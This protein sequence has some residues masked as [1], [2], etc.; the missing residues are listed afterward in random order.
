VEDIAAAMLVYRSA[1]K[2]KIIT[3]NPGKKVMTGL[4]G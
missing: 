3:R 4:A 1:T 2:A